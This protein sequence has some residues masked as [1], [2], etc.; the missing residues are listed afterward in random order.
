MSQNLCVHNRDFGMTEALVR[1]FR[2]GFLKDSDYHHL[3]Q[4]ETLEDVKMNL[5]ETDYDQFLA[6]AP[7]VNPAV[8]LEKA[9]GKMVAEFKY[10]RAQAVEPLATFLDYITYEY[11]IDNVML[12]LKGTLSGRDVGELIEQC[13]PLGLFRD[14]TMRSIPAFE[15]SP[16][17]YADLYQ[18]VLV[19]TPVG[20][21]FSQFL[22]E[23]AER[24][25]SA[26]EV[27]HVLEEVELEIVKHSL[28]KLYLEDFAAFCQSIG[29]DT[30]E[31]MGEILNARADQRAINVTLNSFGTPLN[32]P[33]MRSRER[34][35]LYPSIGFLYPAGT[36]KLA[37]ASDEQAL[38]NAI[39]WH[40][41]YREIYAAHVNEGVDDRSIDDAFYEREVRMLE[42]AF[43]GQ[44]H[45]GI[46]YAYV[47]LKEQ[48]VRNLVWISECIVQQQK[49]EINK[50]VP[51]F[52]KSAPWR[53]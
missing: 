53:S 35:R 7:V 27:R 43:E 33:Q 31:V 23:S 34:R 18:L 9:T 14:S 13:H 39:N 36:H 15:N 10:L 28:M 29:G 5:A 49:D 22:A 21:Y 44:M 52:S 51:C 50:F 17:G 24:I 38:G 8:I 37:E 16:K 42:L 46:Y 48:E 20:P 25:G 47:K 6:D 32:E 11:M 12:L 45:F 26:S 4:C 40:P 3:T 1:G 41:M 30:A 19:D 2:P